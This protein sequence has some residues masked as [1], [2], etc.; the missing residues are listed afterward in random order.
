[1]SNWW[2]LLIGLT[3]YLV[4]VVVVGLGGDEKH[5]STQR[6]LL[7]SVLVAVVVLSVPVVVSAELRNP[8]N[9]LV[10]L[11]FAYLGTLF[12]MSYAK[13]NYCFLFRGITIVTKA[14]SFPHWRGWTLVLGI[15]LIAAGVQ[16]MFIWSGA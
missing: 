5:H 2:F 16:T 6:R 1:M 12:I 4:A 3:I 10:A 9:P 11:Y 13:P 14:V 7:G 8:N 15:C